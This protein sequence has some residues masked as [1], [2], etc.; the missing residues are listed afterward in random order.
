MHSIRDTVALIADTVG[1]GV[2]PGF[3]R[4]PDRANERDLVADS[5]PAVEHLRWRPEVDLPT[6]IARTVDWHLAQLA[7]TA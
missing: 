2:R 6:G 7:R 4:L 3:G 1:A 5:G